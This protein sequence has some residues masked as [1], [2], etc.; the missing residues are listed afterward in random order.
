MGGSGDTYNDIRMEPQSNIAGQ[1]IIT[2][3]D[4]VASI[5]GRCGCGIGVMQPKSRPPPS[6]IFRLHLG[7]SAVLRRHNG[8][9]LSGK[10][11][12]HHVSMKITNLLTTVTVD[13][14][15]AKTRRINYSCKVSHYITLTVD[16]R[17]H[18]A[19]VVSNEWMGSA[20]SSSSSP[21]P[22]LQQSYMEKFRGAAAGGA[23]EDGDLRTKT[24][25]GN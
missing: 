1:Y 16:C 20:G 14:N 3:F 8:P 22:S 2:A 25:N 17:L 12:R 18:S 9:I 5:D 7:E 10:W 23:E 4:N 21:S 13:Q 24:N 15:F 19:P 11:S 6:F